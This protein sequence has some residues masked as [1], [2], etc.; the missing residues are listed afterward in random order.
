M[1]PV[2]VLCA[3]PPWKFGDKLPGPGR[4]AEKHYPCLTIDELKAFPLP[5]L[6]PDCHLFMWRVGAM[7]PE[8]YEVV[9]AWG[10]VAK[11]EVLWLKRT[12]HGKRHFG[13]GR[14]VRYEH[15][16]AIIAT[17]GRPKV[18]AKNIRST[19]G[20]HEPPIRY[21]ETAVFEYLRRR[22]EDGDVEAAGL[23]EACA[24]TMETGHD[25]EE[26]SSIVFSAEAS[27]THSAKPEKFYDIVERLCDGPRAELFARRVREHW[28]CI[29]NEVPAVEGIDAA[30]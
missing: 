19:F 7:V 9:K 18:N 16:V 1:I 23:L 15:E 6:D 5:P 17:R 11:A 12:V 4:G 8:A 22:A 10:F 13:M 3:D 25:E 14:Q 2:K 27:R 26:I 24:V 21:V 20:D 28:T 29:G 30:S